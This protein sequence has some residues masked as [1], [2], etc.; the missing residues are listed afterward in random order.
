MLALVLTPFAFLSFAVRD[1]L[2]LRI[3]PHAR[4]SHRLRDYSIAVLVFVILFSPIIFGNR[5][6]E[7]FNLIWPPHFV[8]ILAG[9]YA[10]LLAASL[11][12]RA[13]ERYHLAWILAV[14]P[15]PLLIIGLAIP[16]RIF[17]PQGQVYGSVLVTS[18][19]ALLWVALICLFVKKADH[20]PLDVTDLDFSLLS[21]GIVH[22]IALVVLPAAALLG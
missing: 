7:T 17:W 13:T 11:W 8:G 20:A 18:L 3:G 16:A 6:D 4:A 12:V 15:N 2:L 14:V 19:I 5:P 1:F 21:A 9:I 22:C 10:G